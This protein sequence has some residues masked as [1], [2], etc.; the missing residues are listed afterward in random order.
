M[1]QRENVGQSRKRRSQ[2]EHRRFL[3]GSSGQQMG[4]YT[5]SSS[6]SPLSLQFVG[7][8]PEEPRDSPADREG[9]AGQLARSSGSCSPQP[10]SSHVLGL[11]GLPSNRRAAGTPHGPSSRV[12]PSRGGSR[13]ASRWAHVDSQQQATQGAGPRGRMGGGARA[14]LGVG[15]GQRPEKRRPGDGSWQG[16]S[17]SASRLGRGLCG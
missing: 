4:F 8:G 9:G 15:R 7:G 5:R 13:P 14:R 10:T 17:W 2:G 1:Q 3:A 6:L 16:S 11:P 12:S